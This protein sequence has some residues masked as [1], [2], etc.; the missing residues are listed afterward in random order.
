MKNKSLQ[1]F[2]IVKLVGKLLRFNPSRLQYQHNPL[3]KLAFDAK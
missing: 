1:A 2:G 3:N